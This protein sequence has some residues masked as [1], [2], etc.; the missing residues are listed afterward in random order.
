MICLDAN[1]LIG[2]TS[3]GRPECGH[4]LSWID[5]GEAFCA[6]APAWYEF[7][8]GPVDTEKVE[9]MKDLVGERIIPF[10]TSSAALAAELFNKIGRPRTRRVDVMIAAVAIGQNAKL[11][12]LNTAHF[13][14]MLKHGLE[15]AR[16]P[17]R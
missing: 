1:Y 10:D 16:V 8:C 6:S 17:T 9:A 12:T 15:L 13:Q 14:P 3:K 7:L 2:G 4:I 11:A 5:A